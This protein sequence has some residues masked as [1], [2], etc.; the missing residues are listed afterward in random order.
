MARQPAA[1]PRSRQG[2]MLT[3]AALAAAGAGISA[4]LTFVHLTHR[5]VFCAGFSSCDTVNASPY[6]ELAGVPVALLGLGAYVVILGLA[7]AAGR[8]TWAEPALLLTA[9]FGLL[10]SAYLTWIELAVIHA[11]CAWCVAS[12][13]VITAITALA[14]IGYLRGDNRPAPAADFDRISGR[15][16]AQAKSSRSRA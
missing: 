5:S 13:I 15:T 11:V 7:L 1:V 12:A 2:I 8:V 16:A 3:I 14:V 10:Y 6:A 4:Y 9:F